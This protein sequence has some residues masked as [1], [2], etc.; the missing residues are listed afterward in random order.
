MC[1]QLNVSDVKHKENAKTDIHTVE[2]G[3][4]SEELQLLLHLWSLNLLLFV[5]CM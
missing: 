4:L 1:I 3:A 2:S 5:V